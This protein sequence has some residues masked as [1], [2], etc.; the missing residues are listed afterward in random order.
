M[1]QAKSKL[2]GRGGPIKDLVGVSAS[3]IER[4]QQNVDRSRPTATE[5]RTSTPSRRAPRPPTV[6]RIGVECL[7][8]MGG[9]ITA[10]NSQLAVQRQRTAGDQLRVVATRRTPT[11][12]YVSIWRKRVATYE[13]FVN[14]RP[15]TGA[16]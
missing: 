5:A 13:A 12:S 7:P 9:L 4:P 11:N 14:R 2:V 3:A 16:R 1:K 10:H 15:A 6:D 8:N